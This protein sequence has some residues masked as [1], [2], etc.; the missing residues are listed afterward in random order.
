MLWDGMDEI[1]HLCIYLFVLLLNCG[2]P[3]CDFS[4]SVFIASRIGDHD[5]V[6]S[7]N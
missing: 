4:K 7:L 5:D 1:E 2:K 3:R 6:V